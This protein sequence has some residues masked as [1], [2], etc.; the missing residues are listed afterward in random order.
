[1]VQSGS[2]DLEGMLAVLDA[3]MGQMGARRI[4]FD[5]IDVVLSMLQDAAT[6]RRELYRLHDWL[7]ARELTAVITS[8]AGVAGAGRQPTGFMQFMVDCAV[9]LEHRVV[10][11]VS[12]R[13][14][15]VVKYRGTQFYENEA[16]YVI[17]SAGLDV[18]CASNESQ[19]RLPVTKERVPTGIPRL[20]TML[21]AVPRR[22]RSGDRS[23]R[24]RQDD[25]ERCIRRC[26]LRTG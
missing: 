2:F 10:Q 13:S 14:L 7:L 21:G 5:A 17:S 25:I 12:Q 8:K 19:A 20:D 16:P 11:G 18:A 6:A 23:A 4:T 1:M 15:R 22:Q 3:K 26:C 9:T 24:H